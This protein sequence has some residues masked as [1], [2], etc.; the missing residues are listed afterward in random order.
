MVTTLVRLY[1]RKRKLAVGYWQARPRIA[2]FPSRALSGHFRVTFRLKFSRPDST[3]NATC[4]TPLPRPRAR[5]ATRELIPRRPRRGLL[6]QTAYQWKAGIAAWLG[7]MFDGLDM[8]LYTLVAAPFVAHLMSLAPGDPAV[9]TEKLPHPGRIPPRLGVWRR[10][11]R[12]AGGQAGA[13]PGLGAH[14]THL[15]A[16]TGLSFFAQTWWELM[17][18]RFLAAL[19]IGGEWAVGSSLLSETWPPRWRACGW[20]RSCKRRQHWGT[21]GVRDQ[22]R[23]WRGTTATSSWWACCRALAVFWD[24]PG[25]ARAG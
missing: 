11:V 1:S 10:R 6:G 4:L 2:S 3:I 12:K 16:F 13:E 18:F 7:W 5:L 19:G 24:P 17:V 9:T 20:R 23:Y 21:D 14:H 15:C 25:R 8:H 22:L